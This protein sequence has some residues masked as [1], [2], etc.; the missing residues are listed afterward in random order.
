M[1]H[2][3]AEFDMLRDRLTS[4]GSFSVAGRVSTAGVDELLVA[5][6]SAGRPSPSLAWRCSRATRWAVSCGSGC[7]VS[8]TRP[9]PRPKS[10]KIS[11]E[12]ISS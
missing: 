6:D 11:T 9:A 8:S 7:C 1:P 12:L 2:P 10:A 3:D 4:S 5:S